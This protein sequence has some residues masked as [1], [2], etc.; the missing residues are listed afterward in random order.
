MN[1]LV[2]GGDRVDAGKTTFS[3][4]LLDR[5]G[6]IG[7]KPRAGNDYWFDHDDYRRAIEQ[8]RL[9]GKDAKRLAT[10]SDAD[11]TPEAINPIHRLWRPSPG[12]GRGLIGGA[13]RQFVLDRAGESFVVNATADVPGSAQ[14][15][16]P[17]DS[18]VTV[19]TVEELNRQTTER[20]L[21][22]LKRLAEEIRGHDRVLIESYGDVA[23]PIANVT[24]DA[25]AIVEPGRVRIF[26]GDRY[27]TACEVVGGAGRGT[28]ATVGGQV[29]AHE[30]RVA[31]VTAHLEPSATVSLPALGSDERAK[32]GAVAD[33]YEVAYDALLGEAID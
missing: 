4:G 13:D 22:R 9:F 29:G 23:L 5:I 20:Y 21:P 7:F 25:V 28:G 16:L 2:A 10:T 27:F 24:V 8:G 17:I 30:E 1:L 11:V 31:D 19:R 12:T 33:A 6:G 26:D 14:D 18:S 32:P 3:T 15:G